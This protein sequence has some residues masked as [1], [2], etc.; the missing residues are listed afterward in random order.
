MAPSRPLIRVL[1]VICFSELYGTQ[2]SLLSTV[3]CLDRAAFEPYVAAPPDPAF[4][5]AVAQAGAR[6]VPVPMRGLA[7]PAAIAALRRCIRELHIDLVHCHL[8]ISSFLGLIAARTRGIPAIV[9]RHIIQDRYTTIPNTALRTAYRAA[10]QAM[11]ARFE[12]I[13]CVSRAVLDAVSD[14]ERPAPGKCVVIPNGVA[15]PQTPPV[16]PDPLP[17]PLR[18]LPSDRGII[19]CTARLAREKG[20]DILLRA[21]AICVQRG[22]DIAVLVAGEGPLRREL[23]QLA[24]S[25]NIRDRVLLAGFRN[26]IPDLLAAA[27]VFVLPAQNE[28]FGIALLE[29]MAAARPV[30]ATAAGGPLELIEPGRSGLL[31]PPADPQALA[32]AIAALFTDPD[33]ARTL[34]LAGRQRVLALFDERSVVRQIQSLYQEILR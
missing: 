8:G 22:L 28:P 31:V 3:R 27:H 21:A 14:R 11:N 9:T 17:A 26:D 29:A 20:L 15:V 1:H 16:R 30:V 6:F 19:F 25:L 18:G 10:Y 32:G 2:R 24:D 12:R 33:R 23:E 4:E 5:A 13:I 34:A 7:D